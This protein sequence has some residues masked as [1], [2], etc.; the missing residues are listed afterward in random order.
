M[1][2]EKRMV[3]RSPETFEYDSMIAGLAECSCATFPIED[4]LIGRAVFDMGRFLFYEGSFRRHRVWFLRVSI[5]L[6]EEVVE[7]RKIDG[8]KF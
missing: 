3:F 1:F 6:G 2:L 4:M 8:E 5:L 7:F